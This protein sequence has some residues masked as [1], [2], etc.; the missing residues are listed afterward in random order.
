M[1]AKK[2]RFVLIAEHEEDSRLI[3]EEVI[4][5][6]DFEVDYAFVGSG[7]ELLDYLKDDSKPRPSLVLTDLKHPLDSHTLES[8]KEDERI[9]AVPLIVITTEDDEFE[10][11]HAYA[12][13]ANSYVMKPANFQ[14]WVDT[15]NQIFTYWFKTAKL[16]SW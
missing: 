8:V 14:S 3:Y 9:S 16:A 2:R 13:C 10:I 12:N 7:Q 15:M 1:E 6:T 4:S 11:R 5:K